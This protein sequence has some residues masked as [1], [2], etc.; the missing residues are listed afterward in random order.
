VPDEVAVD[1]E[2]GVAQ[3]RGTVPDDETARRVG[4]D[5]AHVDGVIGLDNQLEPG[6]TPGDTPEQR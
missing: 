1:V 3:L 6:D 2:E 5:A 4:D